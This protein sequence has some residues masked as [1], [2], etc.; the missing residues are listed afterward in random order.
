VKLAIIGASGY[1]GAKI[2]AEALARGHEAT[3][4]V[5]NTERLAPHAR[6]TAVK[7]DV[8]DAEALCA[9]LAGHDA[10]ISAFNPGKDDTGRGTRSIIEAAG[11]ADPA[12]G[13]RRRGGQPRGRPR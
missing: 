2:T 1:T 9:L 6:L 10:T 3:A 5:R 7:G 8:T 11:R 13:R 12:S 4:I